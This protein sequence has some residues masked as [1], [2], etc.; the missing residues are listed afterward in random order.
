MTLLV[1]CVDTHMCVGP[2][3]SSCRSQGGD[4]GY[5]LITFCF[6][7]ISQGLSVNPGLDIFQLDWQSVSLTDPTVSSHPSTG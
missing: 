5:S 3:V 6:I 7:P 2:C 4:Q 1:I